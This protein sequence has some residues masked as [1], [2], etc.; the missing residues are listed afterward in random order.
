MTDQR[1]RVGLDS[2]RPAADA[3][4]DVAT[5]YVDV[6]R[7]EAQGAEEVELRARNVSK[8]LLELGA[9]QSLVE[10]VTSRLGDETGHGGE[11]ARV[12]V[13]HRDALVTDVVIDGT[14]ESHSHHGP[15]AHLLELARA[16]ADS[17]RYAV[18]LTD[19]TGADITLADTLGPGEVELQSEGDHEVLHKVGGGG[20]SHRR[21]QSR[22]EDSWDR[23][24]ETVARDL[25]GIVRKHDPEVVLLAG[26]EYACSRVRETVAGH[27]AERLEL[28]E[29]GSRAA[30]ASDER[31]EEDVA[32]AVQRCRTRRIDAVLDRLGAAEGRKAVGP[33]ETLDALR[34]GEVETL[35]LLDG[36]L[37]G[38]EAAVG[39]DPLHLGHTTDEVRSLGVDDPATDRLDEVLVRA[40]IGQ[41]ADLL[42][43]HAPVGALPD[44]VGA[45]LRFDS[46]AG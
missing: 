41:D 46:T 40:A 17:V 12:L 28:I 7:T 18:V 39:P 22:V 16:M 44:G 27:V 2:L 37:D 6:S 35:I 36:A 21:W 34:R 5:A 4:G 25:D 10:R 11:V 15:I 24:A 33:G 19:H 26:D 1:R 9:D 42:A 32:A 29:H 14:I 23:N 20:W 13:A 8:E 3:Y 31:M 38:R 43:L 45:V 30:G